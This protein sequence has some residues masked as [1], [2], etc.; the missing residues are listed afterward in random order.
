MKNNSWQERFLIRPYLS[1][2]EKLEENL[3]HDIP[4][5]EPPIHSVSANYPTPSVIFRMFDLTDVSE[6]DNQN[7]PTPKS[8][9]R[10]IIEEQIEQTLKIYSKDKKMVAERL[11]NMPGG[12]RI[13]IQAMVVEVLFG[14]LFRLPVNDDFI[15]MYTCIFIE[16]C[17]YQPVKVP[18][19]ISNACEI[20]FTRL[21]GMSIQA[22]ERF[23]NWF[24]HH[25]SNF[26]FLW[27]WDNWTGEDNLNEELFHSP[28]VLFVKEIFEN[29]LRLS[30]HSK[31]TDMI[32]DDIHHLLPKEPVCRFKF[33]R[34]ARVLKRAADEDIEKM[35]DSQN[36][37]EETE[38][39]PLDID[40]SLANRRDWA[41]KLVEL[42]TNRRSSAEIIEFLSQI[43]R[44]GMGPDGNPTEEGCHWEAID[45]FITTILE[46][47]KRSMSH[48]TSALNSFMNVFMWLGKTEMGKNYILWT[49]FEVWRDHK[50]MIICLVDKMLSCCVLTPNSVIEWALNP[51]L[52][53]ELSRAW[54]WRIISNT[55]RKM[56]KHVFKIENELFDIRERA[57]LLKNEN[58]NVS[59]NNI[60]DNE[61]DML[62][63]YDAHAPDNEEIEKCQKKLNQAR[64]QQKKLILQTFQKV[65]NLILHQ[66][67]KIKVLKEN[68]N[69]AAKYEI[70]NEDLLL[71]I[72]RQRIT[73]LLLEFRENAHENSMYLEKLVF[74]E[75]D[76]KT[77]GIYRSFCEL[78]A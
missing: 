48:T 3:L 34:R 9:E 28:Q 27:G 7:L 73:A 2:Q 33:K 4:V 1:F 19:V 30:Y 45:V 13:P 15:A 5:F 23:E 26:Q 53:S 12:S 29:C 39:D 66:L 8:I 52:A 76:E 14:K 74:E 55:L 40:E 49:I 22:R 43:E 50:Q 59:D 44:S 21:N 41:K 37:M 25:L 70:D 42:V 51:Q 57:L 61:N 75:A 58:K 72:F 64:D 62:G 38:E 10:F 46:Y 56:R 18:P 35:G 20:V 36:E 16:L 24:A 69:T 68:K 32:P 6:C 67:N 60:E 71:D 17:K 54:L 63:I 31:L 11:L 77:Q 65:C 47:R 78:S